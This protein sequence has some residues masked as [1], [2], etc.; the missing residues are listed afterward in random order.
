MYHNLIPRNQRSQ[1][2]DLLSKA[3]KLLPTLLVHPEHLPIIIEAASAVR[4]SEEVIARI[5]KPLNAQHLAT[6]SS[7]LTKSRTYVRNFWD[8]KD[9]TPA[10]DGSPARREKGVITSSFHNDITPSRHNTE[11]PTTPTNSEQQ[12]TATVQNGF[13]VSIPNTPDTL[14]QYIH[15]LSPKL[16]H[17]AEILPA[18]YA[19][20]N[21]THETLDRLARSSSS[22]SQKDAAKERAY[23]A[24]KTDLL[25]RTIDAF[26]NRVHAERQAQAGQP[27][28]KE[29][30]AYLDEEEKKYPM[31]EEVTR[32]W[33][34]YSK[35]EIDQLELS[36]PDPNVPIFPNQQDAPTIAQLIYARQ[37]RNKKLLR[38]APQHIT[39]KAKNERILAMNELHEWG[40]SIEKKQWEVLL[41][42]GI[43]VPKD[44]LNPFLT[45]SPEEKKAHKQ[46]YDHDRYEENKPLEVKLNIKRKMR[47]S[48]K[49]DNPYL[50]K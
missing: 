6:L 39:E 16:Q 9:S 2:L 49:E 38:R 12:P 8:M 17:Q 7:L 42:M 21:D 15:T 47:K 36:Q 20:L 32:R 18:K 28:T 25:T 23:Y 11:K 43:E 5:K 19:E 14:K 30:Q 33:G 27:I 26:W 31:E 35:A 10:P 48:K 46:A 3:E 41:Q 22:S 29:Y 34:D 45:M 37:E 44:Y 24:K 40:I 13:A 4:G 1:Y 50:K